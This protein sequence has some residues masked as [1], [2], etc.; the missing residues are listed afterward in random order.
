MHGVACGRGEGRWLSVLDARKIR[1]VEWRSEKDVDSGA[2]ERVEGRR[3]RGVVDGTRVGMRRVEL[4][5]N[6]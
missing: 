6:F 3:R 5:S 1:R 4:V 2:A